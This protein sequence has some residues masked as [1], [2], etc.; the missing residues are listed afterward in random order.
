LDVFAL[1]VAL[2]FVLGGLSVALFTAAAERLGSRVGGL[3]LS[4]PVK[5]TIAMA[6][7]GLNEG[8]SVAAAAATAIPLGIGINLVF[9]G[10]TALLVR[11]FEARLAV[12]AALGVW[13]AGGILAILF[14]PARLPW[15]AL[16]WIVPAALALALIPRA[17]GARPSK[18]SG[19]T[20]GVLGLLTRAA[21]AGTIVALAVVLARYGGPLLGGL[22]SVFPS[23]W[24]TTMVILTRHHGAAFTGE[25]VRVMVAG[26]TAPVAFGYVIWWT[27]PILG[28]ALGSAAAVCA[29][30]TV[31]LTLAAGLRLSPSS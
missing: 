12:A 22:A 28:V 10:A 2:S 4:F 14:V 6:L 19:D 24:I 27:F 9:L 7:I 18:R 23:G 30:L 31:S 15:S 26:S 25:T 29:A 16:A 8:A 1:R 3:L 11:R 20:F 13:L 5:V 17:A 21:G